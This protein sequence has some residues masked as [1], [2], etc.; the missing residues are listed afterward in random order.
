MSLTRKLLK[1]MGLTEEQVDTIIEAHTD[2]VDGLKADLKT[3]Q[4]G[5]KNTSALE[6]KIRELEGDLEAAKKD[7]WKDKHDSVKKEFDDYKADIEAEK[8]RA[9]KENAVRSYFEGKNITGENL[10]LA[11]RGSRD[12]V[13]ALELDGDKI[14]DTKALDELVSGAFSR[15]VSTTKTVG[16]NTSTPPA[17]N[18]GGKM[19]R[20]EIVK[21]KDPAERR[22]AIR[23]NFELFEKG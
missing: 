13:A 15:L 6:K 3:A 11:M 8:T 23:D 1:G 18:G 21:I 9:T 2:T 20:D 7:G 17:N 14:K 16:A 12:E 22:A 19:T 5:V 4:E 10:E